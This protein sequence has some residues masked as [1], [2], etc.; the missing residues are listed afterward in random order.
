VANIEKEVFKE[1]KDSKWSVWSAEDQHSMPFAGHLDCN[2]D[3]SNA[4]DKRWS[5][6]KDDETHTCFGCGVKVPEH[7]QGLVILLGKW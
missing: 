5:W 1:S 3:E 6:F 4:F 2:R 7:I